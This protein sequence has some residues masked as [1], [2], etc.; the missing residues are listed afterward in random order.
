MPV[1]R[2]GDSLAAFPRCE[3]LAQ[4]RVFFAPRFCTQD[5]KHQWHDDGQADDPVQQAHGIAQTLAA[6]IIK[7]ISAGDQHREHDDQHNA[8]DP[9]PRQSQT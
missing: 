3:A 4:R 6:R 7:Q 2:L 1:D 5:V 8:A 9:T